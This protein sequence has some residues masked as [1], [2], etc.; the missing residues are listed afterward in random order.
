MIVHVFGGCAVNPRDDLLSRYKGLQNL[1]R[2]TSIYFD[3]VNWSKSPL[4]NAHI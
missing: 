1:L 2:S 3:V 4:F